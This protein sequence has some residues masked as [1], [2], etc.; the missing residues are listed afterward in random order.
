MPSDYEGEPFPAIDAKGGRHLLTP[1][2][3]GRT[4]AQGHATKTNAA[5]DCVGLRT[6]DGRSVAR[7]AKGRYL[8][9]DSDIGRQVKLFADGPKVP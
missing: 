8:V 6:Q 4:D 2:Y 1:T 3:R 5:R 7:I 9:A